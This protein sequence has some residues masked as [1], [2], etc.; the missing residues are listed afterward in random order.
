MTKRMDFQPELGENQAKEAREREVERGKR[1]LRR[2]G[3]EYSWESGM[4]FQVSALAY[5]IS[6]DGGSRGGGQQRETWNSHW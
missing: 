4:D 3:V 5:V 1:E 2:S 6:A